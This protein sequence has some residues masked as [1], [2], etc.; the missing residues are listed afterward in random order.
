MTKEAGPFLAN[1]RYNGREYCQVIHADTWIEAEDRLKAMSFGKIVGSN[2]TTVSANA[3]TNPLIYVWVHILMW[4]RNWR[5]E[6]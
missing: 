3:L 2:C 6:R 5:D 1:Y 4:Y